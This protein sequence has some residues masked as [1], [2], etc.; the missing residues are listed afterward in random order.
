MVRADLAGW[1]LLLIAMAVAYFVCLKASKEGS[2]VFQIGGYAIGILILAISLVL[3][4]N[5]LIGNRARRRA[6][7]SRSPK[8][9]GTRVPTR[10]TTPSTRKLPQKVVI[11][12]KE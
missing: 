9:T 10:I 1:A 5:N 2:K 7:P 12:E 6:T 11:P 4:L 8:V 3:V